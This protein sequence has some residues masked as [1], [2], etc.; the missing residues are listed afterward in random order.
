[1]WSNGKLSAE[2]TVVFSAGWL[3]IL[4]KALS[5]RYEGPLVLFTP[6][7]ISH[8]VWEPEFVLLDGVGGCQATRTKKFLF[9]SSHVTPYRFYGLSHESAF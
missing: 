5:Q 9:A 4:L 7:L 1:V 3:R 8:R 6:G 2:R